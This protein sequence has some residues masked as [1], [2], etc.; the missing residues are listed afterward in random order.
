ML[1]TLSLVLPVLIPSWR[2]FKTVEP[3]PRVQWALIPDDAKAP[4]IWSNFQPPPQT[5][6]PLQMVRRLFW[7]P[8]R[9]DALFV[10]SCAERIQQQPTPHS[11][12]EIRTRIQ[13]DIKHLDIQPDKAHLKFRLVFVH[14]DQSGR[15]EKV[16]FTSDPF[17]AAADRS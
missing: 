15:V 13:R 10:I 3:S 5:M 4:L 1:T 16:V 17:P 14:R 12:A 7:N 11:I 9:N 8:D 2:F 6:P